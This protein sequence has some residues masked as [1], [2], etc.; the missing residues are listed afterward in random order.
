MPGRTRS[1]LSQD[2]DEL[3]AKTR[4]PQVHVK[5]DNS[6]DTE[7]TSSSVTG[8]EMRPAFPAV[9][10]IGNNDRV[11]Q[12]TGMSKVKKTQKRKPIVASENK[13][14]RVRR[15]APKTKRL[16]PA[17]NTQ[18]F[19]DASLPPT[20]TQTTTQVRKLLKEGRD[21][22]ITRYYILY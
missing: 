11:S 12:S 14:T 13:V 6:W 10:N 4:A 21:N 16:G 3:V 5:S 22:K 2:G 19:A 20:A 18:H 1:N 7:E 17:C 8:P 15:R 9:A